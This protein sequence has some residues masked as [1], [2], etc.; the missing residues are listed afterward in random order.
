MQ[1]SLEYSVILEPCIESQSQPM[2]EPFIRPKI[3]AVSE[4]V[5]IGKHHNPV[6]DDR[7]GKA[8]IS[9]GIYTATMG[10]SV[11]PCLKTKSQYCF[12]ER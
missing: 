5:N 2:D 7:E 10:I 6:G 11:R 1:L 8:M 9:Q 3:L 12:G 4:C